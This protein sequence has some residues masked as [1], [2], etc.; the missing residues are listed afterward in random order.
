MGWTGHNELTIEQV[1]LIIQ[2][3][4]NISHLLTP[5]YLNS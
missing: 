5:D 4:K 1:E 3:C 2:E